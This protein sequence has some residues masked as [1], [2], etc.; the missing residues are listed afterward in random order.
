[1]GR[2]LDAPIVIDE[3]EQIGEN[4]S[5]EETNKIVMKLKD[6]EAENEVFFKI[7]ADIPL[8]WVMF[9]YC[10][11]AKVDFQSTRFEFNGAKLRETDTPFQLGMRLIDVIDVSSSSVDGNSSA[12]HYVT[13]CIRMHKERDIFY[14]VRRCAPLLPQLL[15]C[16][17]SVAPQEDRSISF[18]YEGLKLHQFHT[19]DQL[20]MRDGD[21]VDGFDFNKM[22]PSLSTNTPRLN[23]KVVNQSTGFNSDFTV[24]QNTL[25]CRLMDKFCQAEDIKG[26]KFFGPTGRTLS[27]HKTVHEEQLKHGDTISAVLLLREN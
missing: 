16:L 21:V 8:R 10:D 11:I 17:P 25:L 26:L 12:G 18:A 2:R 5:Q 7:E 4:A 20:H 27:A 9:R 3:E 23:L 22:R 1:M 24:S 15:Q 13:L 6:L 14:R 19:A